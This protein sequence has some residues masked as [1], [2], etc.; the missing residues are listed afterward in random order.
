MKHPFLALTCILLLFPL[1]LGAAGDYPLTISLAG[2]AQTVY[3]LDEQPKMLWE[4]D[5]VIF[6]TR[7]SSVSVERKQFKGFSF[8]SPDGIKEVSAGSVRISG[9]TDK[10]YTVEG[11]GSA[12][13]VKV[14]G[15]DGR[16]VPSDCVSF[17]G[18]T[19]RISLQPLPAGIYIIQAGRHPALKVVKP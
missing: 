3:P 16:L 18:Q 11:I 12:G 9:S 19:A 4:G 2:G 17:S 10:G 6:T 8:G 7:T 13:D 15:P 1:A 5:Q 14:F